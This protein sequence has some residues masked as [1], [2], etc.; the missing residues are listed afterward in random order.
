M[1]EG[2]KS[3]II[4]YG[5]TCVNRRQRSAVLFEL[6]REKMGRM[7]GKDDTVLWKRSRK[8]G[9]FQRLRFH[10]EPERG[11]AVRQAA[12]LAGTIDS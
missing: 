11:S 4:K 5:A 3:C 10:D 2:S 8:V 9:V 7:G 1:S 12:A 6:G